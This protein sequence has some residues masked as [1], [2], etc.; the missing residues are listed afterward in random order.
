MAT[1]DP[2]PFPLVE[3]QAVANA[4]NQWVALTL[5]VDASGGTVRNALHSVFSYPDMLAALAP[6]DCIV[7]VGAP[8][9]LTPD[10]LDLMPPGRIIFA[11]AG[12]ALAHDGACAHIDALHQRGYRI[13][14]DGPV[15]HGAAIPRCLYS[16][17]F[18]CGQGAPSQRMSAS[19]GGPHLARNIGSAERFG[20]CAEAGFAW[21][22]GSYPLKPGALAGLNDGTSRK[23]LLALLGLLTRDAESCD[24]EA[25]LKQDPALSYQL[26]KLVNSAAFALDKPIAS[27]GQAI[28]LLGRRQLQRWLQL[29]LYARQGNEPLA[30]PLLPLAA[31]RAAQL[32]AL[33]KL[34][35]GDREAQ[36]LA[37]MVGVFSLLDML[38]AM[39]MQEIVATLKL[40]PEV[41]SALTDR[42]G[43]LGKLLGMVETEAADLACLQGEHIEPVV[44]WQSQL[45]GYHWA[46][47]V[48]RDN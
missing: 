9:T 42:A 21:F 48:S 33:C 25:L 16:V 46:I 14:L 32:E 47:Q 4:R 15:P 18:D 28:S 6:L 3:M 31:L 40:A 19:K 11:I 26:F 43:R 20:E 2:P 7:L 23:R 44:W 8:S 1:S 45:E 27:F 17:A 35:G 34:Q 36:D 29:L 12:A 39:P 10:L 5:A 37:F 41:C 22:S 13:L 38:F 30:N 24:I